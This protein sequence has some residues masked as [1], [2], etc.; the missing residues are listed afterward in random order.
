MFILYFYFIFSFIYNTPQSRYC[1]QISTEEKR[2]ENIISLQNPPYTY[3]NPYEGKLTQS[4]RLTANDWGQDVR[5]Y[6]IQLDKSMNFTPGDSL[7]I[8]PCNPIT[9]VL[10]FL[11]RLNISPDTII[12]SISLRD[13]KSKFT[14]KKMKITNKLII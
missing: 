5:H 9:K 6:E 4:N 1:I 13:T 12:E 10:E 7:A 11:K 3:S 2:N 8:L 14:N